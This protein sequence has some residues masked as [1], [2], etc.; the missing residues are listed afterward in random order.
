MLV[1]ASEGVCVG[2]LGYCPLPLQDGGEAAHGVD[3]LIALDGMVDPAFHG[4]G[5]F[6]QLVRRLSERLPEDVPYIGFPNHRSFGI[7]IHKLG[8]VSPGALKV[9]L[10]PLGFGG[11]GRCSRLLGLLALLARPAITAY[12]G[13]YRWRGERSPGVEVVRLEDFRTVEP[14]W[15]R[16]RGRL[17]ITFR[18]DPAALVWRFEAAPDDYLQLAVRV[19]GE[20]VGMVVFKVETRFGFTVAWVMDA[21]VDAADPKEEGAL[22]TAALLQAEAFLPPAV[23][24]ASLLLPHHRYARAVARAGYR[25]LPQKLLPHE[26]FF[27]VR[28]NGYPET[29][30]NIDHWYL[31]WSLHDVL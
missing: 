20:V 11:L 1:A 23:D 22:L 6:Q 13:F 19:A 30:E 29:V 14:A 4:L 16:A 24:F 12:R 26:F 5:I 18:R 9:R 21:F 8:W 17:G 10:K 25:W 31:S 28:R 7:F 2:Y 15:Q 3:A 27:I